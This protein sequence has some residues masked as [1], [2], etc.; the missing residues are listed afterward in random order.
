MS[1]GARRASTAHATRHADTREAQHLRACAQGAAGEPGCAALRRR[2]RLRLAPVRAP[3]CGAG[4]RCGATPLCSRHVGAHQAEPCAAR[5]RGRCGAWCAVRR[6]CKARLAS[7][8]KKQLKASGLRDKRVLTTEDL[9]R[10]LKEVRGATSGQAGG[11]GQGGGGGHTGGTVLWS[12]GP[13]GTWGRLTCGPPPRATAAA[14][15]GV[16]VRQAPYLTDAA[17]GPGQQADAG[18]AGARKA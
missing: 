15:F 5:C 3:R 18:G 4:A 17:P 14:Q 11:V 8:P 7:A 13:R 12:S 2:G 6:L 9:A 10:V 16:N 1:P